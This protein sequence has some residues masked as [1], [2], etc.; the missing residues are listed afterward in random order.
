MI[1]LI[2]SIMAQSGAAGGRMTGAAPAAAGGVGP[3][4]GVIRPAAPVRG[5]AAA[6][7]GLAAPFRGVAA[8]AVGPAAPIVGPGVGNMVGPL[9]PQDGIQPRFNVP[10]GL[11]GPAPTKSDIKFKIWP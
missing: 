4:G 6:A 9:V 7:V 8:P 11:L 10:A 1:T 5:A 2:T 3:G